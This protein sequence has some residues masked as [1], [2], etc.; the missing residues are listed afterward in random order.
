MVEN[1]SATEHMIQQWQ[2][3]AAEK[4]EKFGRMQQEIE[5]ISATETSRDGA[6]QATIGSNGILQDIQLSDN[7]AKRPMAKLGA[8]I[9]RAVQAAQAKIPTLMQQAVSNTVGL[10]DVAAQHVLTQAR[11]N[12]PEPPEDEPEAPRSHGHE[13]REMQFGTADDYEEP[14]NRPTPPAARPAPPQQQQPAR[15]PDDFDDG[16]FSNQSFLR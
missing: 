9:M 4:A 7:A 13:V 8:E 12:F 6:I 15:R 2:E 5:Q 10:D 16:D 14:A 1:I 11:K 3:R